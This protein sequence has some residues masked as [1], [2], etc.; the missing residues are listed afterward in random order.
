MQKLKIGKRAYTL[1][2]PDTLEP[3]LVRG[4]VHYIN[5]TI[6]V[7]ERVGVP[8]RKRS[9]L[10][11]QHTLWHEITHAIL[12]DMGSAKYKDEHFVDELAKRIRQVNAQLYRV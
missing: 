6:Q 10:G 12:H 4:R 8:R 5:R 11:M 2:F 3:A 1:S 9:E 7:A